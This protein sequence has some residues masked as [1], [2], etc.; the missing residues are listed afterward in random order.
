M[1]FTVA[2]DGPA[3]AGKGTIARAVAARFGFAHLDTGVLY[4]IVGKRA[5][6]RGRGAVDEDSAERAARQLSAA[7]LGMTGL[8]TVPIAR[9]AS[10]VAAM[11]GVRAAL[12]GLQRDFA[13]RDG[14]AV[15][16]GRDI[17]TAI[18]PN[19]EVKLFVTASEEARARRRFEE[20]TIRGE[21]TTLARVSSDLAMRDARD[22]QRDAAPMVR[23]ED[24]VLLDTTDMDIDEAIAAAA[25]L[26]EKALPG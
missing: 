15:L 20:L 21:K 9:A 18:C 17:G 22:S 26:V 24:A 4:R 25:R 16:D 11:P 13:R 1:R 14:G 5:L 12:I 2:I 7:D 23:A 8:R 3:A 10:R 6:D 19:A